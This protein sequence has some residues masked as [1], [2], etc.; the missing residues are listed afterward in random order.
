MTGNSLQAEHEHLANLLEA[1][2]RCAYF[3][4]A[5]RPR[6][7]GFDAEITRVCHDIGT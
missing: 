1:V 4:R 5:S 6:W 3:M 2:Q 7:P